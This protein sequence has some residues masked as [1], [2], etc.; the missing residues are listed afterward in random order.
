MKPS[1]LFFFLFVSVLFLT[2]ISARVE[3]EES[4]FLIQT[5]VNTGGTI[6]DT[7]WLAN[8]TA[9]NTSWSAGGGASD[10]TW[11]AK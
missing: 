10:A 1:K 4:R 6:N 11:I 7:T 5:I 9:Y 8:W 2:T 3:I